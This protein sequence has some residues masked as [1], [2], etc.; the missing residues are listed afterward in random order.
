MIQKGKLKPM[1][2]GA[3][4]NG[5]DKYGNRYGGSS[6]GQP[7]LNISKVKLEKW[8]PGEGRN[9]VDIIPFAATADNPLVK[10]GKAEEGDTLYSLDYFVHNNVGPNSSS[11][12]CLRQ[13]GG[14][15]PCCN[16][17]KRLKDSGMESEIY[18]K[19]RVV[20]IVHD[21]LHDKYGVWDTGYKSVEK[22]LQQEAALTTN[23]NGERVNVMDPYEGMSLEFQGTPDSFN[24][25]DFFKPTRFRF[26]KREPLSDEVLSHATDLATVMNFVDEAAMEKMLSGA[27]HVAAPQTA[28]ASVPEAKS[29]GKTETSCPYGH[30]WHDADKHDECMSCPVWEKCYV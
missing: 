30:P 14:N 6:F 28:Q 11:V 29:E 27:S 24:G 10:S 23:E 22:E 26:V 19:R 5:A 12:P 21:L 15:C 25:N 17:S 7:A 20:Y 8:K 18:A 9:L 3:Y 1:K 16:E 4:E 2:M 13:F